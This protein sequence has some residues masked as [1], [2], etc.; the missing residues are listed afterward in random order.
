MDL[1]LPGRGAPNGSS[2]CSIPDLHDQS[3]LASGPPHILKVVWRKQG[4]APCKVRSLLQC[5]FHV[6][7]KCN[8]EHKSAY[9]DEVNLG[10]RRFWGYYRI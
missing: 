8:D 3:L 4:Y 10:H 2:G 7:I 1:V 5:L 9:K 6:S